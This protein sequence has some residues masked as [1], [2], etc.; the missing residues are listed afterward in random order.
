MPKTTV[1]PKLR[2]GDQCQYI[3]DLNRVTFLR[4]GRP[5]ADIGVKGS[6][7]LSLRDSGE[8]L[9][10]V[11]LLCDFLDFNMEL[12]TFSTGGATYRF[13]AR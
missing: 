11:T 10:F 7:K 13:V 3:Y 12:V 9:G 8:F 1:V 2:A 4:G 5:I 6:L